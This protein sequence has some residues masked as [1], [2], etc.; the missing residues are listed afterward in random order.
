MLAHLPMLLHPDPQEV[1][2]IGFGMG[3]TTHS[4]SLYKP[5]RLDVIEIAP[6]VLE[7]APF[8][9]R[10]NHDVVDDPDLHIVIEDGRNYLLRTRRHPD[11]V[12]ADPTHPILGSGSLYTKEYYE[13]TYSRLGPDGVMG[14]Y[15]PLHLLGTQEFKSVMATFASVFEHCSLWYSLT[16]LVL[17][18]SKQPLMIDYHGL[19]SVMAKPAI[20]RDLKLSNI[21]EP[22]RLLSHF[23]MGEDEI[24]QYSKGAPINTD[25]H[26]TV[27]FHGARSIGT[28]MRPVNLAS[29]RPYLASV[30]RCVDLSGVSRAERAD[31]VDRL[32]A[33]ERAQPYVIDGMVAE[34][35]REPEMALTQYQ[36][37]LSAY[38]DFPDVADRVRALRSRQRR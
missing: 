7:G 22:L 32:D 9:R 30:K 27:E 13:Q 10:L 6:E 36:T 19:A 14:Q 5:R 23:L 8:F 4:L 18:G 28:D 17:V 31:V 11:V 15:M 2:V 29:V 21:D 16:D 37:A 26:P 38:E 1:V 12:T 20:Q 34:Y 3:V 24:P 25:D 33:I 35:Q